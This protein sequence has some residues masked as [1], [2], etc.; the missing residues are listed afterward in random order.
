MTLALASR[1]SVVLLLSLLIGGAAHATTLQLS[2][3]DSFGCQGSSISLDVVSD[4]SGN[5][6]VTLGIDSTNYDGSK[7]GVVQAGFKAI[8]GFSSVTLVSFTDGSWSPAVEGGVSSSS[9]CAPNSS[10]DF[11]CTSG[12]AD[13]VNDTSSTWV[14]KVAGGT[15]L[16]EWTIK[17]Q[18]GDEQAP[19]NGYSGNI[20][21]APGTPGDPGNPVPEP[22][23]A[24]VFG[25]ALLVASRGARRAR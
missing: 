12:Y 16:P 15:V 21:S 6:D 24:L 3:C 11:A 9:L 7:S 23:A 19:K 8:E 13:V 1:L 17:F 5:W 20:I 18:Y 4:G 2:D 25:V 14:F 10:S 22:S